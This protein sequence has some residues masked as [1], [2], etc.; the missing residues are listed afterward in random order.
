MSYV[1]C[2]CC[3][4]IIQAEAGLGWWEMWE[5]ITTARARDHR[6]GWAQGQP[7][8]HNPFTRWLSAQPAQQAH[9]SEPGG[10][11]KTPL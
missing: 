4:R 3:R 11:K 1:L 10:G 6:W 2:M 8:H 9:T 5:P 7:I